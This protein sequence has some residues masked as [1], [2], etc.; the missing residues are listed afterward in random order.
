[1]AL[2]EGKGPDLFNVPQA[3][4]RG[5]KEKLLPIPDERTVIELGTDG[6]GKAAN[7]SRKK[8]KM[9]LLDLRRDYAEVAA[10]AVVFSVVTDVKAQ[11]REDR[12]FGLPFSADTLALYYNR[13]LLKNADLS[14]PAKT[15]AQLQEQSR[16]LSRRDGDG[17]LVQSGVALG[18]SNV[19]HNAEILVALMSQN[20]AAINTGG[21]LSF[22]S[23]PPGWSRSGTPALEALAFYLGFS[24]PNSV[25]WS[26]DRGFD[27]D[28]DAFIAGR[29][30]YYFG[31]PED[32]RRIRSQAPRLDLGVA[33]LPQVKAADR[34]NIALFPV[35][36][37]SKETANPDYAWDFSGVR[38]LSRAGG[39]VPLRRRPPGRPAVP[40]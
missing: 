31:F 37:V 10:E 9:S 27:N 26:W 22:W 25:N 14:E 2:A 23:V 3:W 20:G 32:A 35:E 38:R 5:W 6:D 11:T 33:P 8:A 18:W 13:D 29:T 1:M 30:A 36:V 16:V 34:S 28:L 7:V 12:I 40:D 39:D 19:G 17:N 24:D 15:W 4:L 21:R